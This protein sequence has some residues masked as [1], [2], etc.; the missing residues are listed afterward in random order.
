MK[1]FAVKTLSI[2]M[3]A[4]FSI[5]AFAADKTITKEVNLSSP[6]LVGE[7]LLPA[8]D[9]KV[10][11]AGDSMTFFQTGIS[12]KK[13]AEAKVTVTTEKAEQ[14]IRTNVLNLVNN[15]KNQPVLIGLVFGGSDTKYV[16]AK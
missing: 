12:K 1:N 6:T 16:V 13:A 11:V 3:I 10:T 14:K 9:Y 8:G 4:L 15:E 5:A 7:K 2:A